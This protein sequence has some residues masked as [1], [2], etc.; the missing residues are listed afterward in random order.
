MELTGLAET[1]P[2][3]ARHQSADADP[4]P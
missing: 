1:D 4:E 2:E 3:P